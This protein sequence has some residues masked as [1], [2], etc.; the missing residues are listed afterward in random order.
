MGVPTNPRSQNKSH[1]ELNLNFLGTNLTA[2]EMGAMLTIPQVTCE[3]DP[4]F[5]E[6]VPTKNSK[7]RLSVNVS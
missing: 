1:M 4:H 7:N 6:C 2:S 5:Y 3:E